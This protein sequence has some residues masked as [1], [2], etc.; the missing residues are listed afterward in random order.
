[1]I[2]QFG[3]RPEILLMDVSKQ[4]TSRGRLYD[5]AEAFERRLDLFR[6]L[7]LPMLK[8][9]DAEGRLRILDGDT[10]IP[11][12]RQQFASALLELMRRASRHED[13]PNRI[14][15]LRDEDEQP[16]KIGV[17]VLNGYA[18]PVAN[19]IDHRGPTIG[20][21]A[22]GTP[23]FF[24]ISVFVGLEWNFFLVFCLERGKHI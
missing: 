8:A 20:N 16:R 18:K 5:G 2:L 15:V 17:G 22:A 21:G 3:Q 7:A 1:M 10:E 4:Q 14:S 9:L 13:D 19:G 24:F 12:D 23:I 6:K 11:A